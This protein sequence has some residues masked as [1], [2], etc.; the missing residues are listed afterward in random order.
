LTKDELLKKSYEI[1]QRCIE[2]KFQ[3][4]VAK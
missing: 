4:L 3:V 1:I 2:W